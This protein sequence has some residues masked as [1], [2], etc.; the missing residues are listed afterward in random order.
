MHCPTL[1]ELPFPDTKKNGW[2]FTDQTSG[3]VLPHVE[4]W[5]RITVVTPSYNQAQYLEETIRSVLLQGYPNLEYIIIDGGS[6]DHSV[7]IIKKYEP[8]LAY[9]VSEPDRG[10]AHAINKGFACASGSL[11]GWINS[12]D[13]LLPGALIELG[14]MH[15][16]NGSAILLGDVINF[17]Q[18]YNIQTYVAQREVTFERLI[19]PWRYDHK[20]FWHQPGTYVP[21]ELL[22]QVAPLDEDLRYLFDLDWMCRLVQQT[23]VT[24]LHQPVAR[25]RIH[26]TSK[27]TG[28]ALA[29]FHEQEIIVDRYK[30]QIPDFD[31]KLSE[32]ALKL[33]MA[34]P[35]L[36]L[37]H[38]NR[39]QGVKYLFQ[40]LTTDW[41]TIFLPRFL[42]LLGRAVT[43]AFVLRGARFVHHRVQCL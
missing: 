15:A 24:Y 5:P 36:R 42:E 28:E 23:S 20:L 10:Q 22:Q 38:L 19:E 16:A 6:T 41:R 37:N 40:A 9:W 26:Q 25:F 14:Q 18:T 43:P 11:I 17:N 35:Y 8:W 30:S 33:S 7:D 2:P 27:T 32:A 3:T 4:S 1:T 13:L 39:R 31:N 12:D 29:W 34:A 21:V